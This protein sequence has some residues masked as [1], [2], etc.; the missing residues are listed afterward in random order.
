VC[1][2]PFKLPSERSTHERSL[3]AGLLLGETRIDHVIAML[4]R[5]SR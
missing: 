3:Y 5:L 2:T 1:P 4:Y